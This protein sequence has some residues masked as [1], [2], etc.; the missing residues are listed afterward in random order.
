M[1]DTWEHLR[2]ERSNLSTFKK[3]KNSSSVKRKRKFVEYNLTLKVTMLE[4]VKSSKTITIRPSLPSMTKS[5]QQI[6]VIPQ[7]MLVNGCISAKSLKAIIDEK[8]SQTSIK[9]AENRH[10]LKRPNP[11]VCSDYGSD[12][13]ASLHDDK[14]VRKR[15]NLDH[16]SPEEKLM[17][18]KLK[19]RVAA[20]N[21][22][23][24]KRVKM[25]EMELEL[26]RIKAHAKA[27]E[28]K[29]AKL[30]SDNARLSA[31]ND[32][33]R[34]G[35]TVVSGQEEEG[36]LVKS[37]FDSAEEVL[38]LGRGTP[39]KSPDDGFE[40]VVDILPEQ[41][42]Q[43]SYD[44]TTYKEESGVEM[45]NVMGSLVKSEDFSNDD[46]TKACEQILDSFLQ[47]NQQ[48]TKPNILD[49]AWEQTFNDLDLSIFPDL[50]ECF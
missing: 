26:K 36:S 13:E 32:S 38:R 31:E 12:S 25:E 19:N 42:Q 45:A 14:P 11:S 50:G 47:I 22:R 24:K 18:R 29:N 1:G 48:E 3:F 28:M 8:S 2:P 15:A 40:V 21:A 39:L 41:S 37:Q 7:N 27:L 5:Q 17:R 43:T 23:D 44:E 4:T 9:M 34:N 46:E 10:S 6:I 49:T 35:Q 33:L 20:Q 30:V 16:L